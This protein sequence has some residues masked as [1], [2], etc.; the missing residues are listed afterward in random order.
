MH[1]DVIEFAEAILNRLQALEECLLSAIG[2]RTREYVGKELGRVADLLDR[3]AQLVPAARVKAAQL[4]AAL[5][6]LLPA[7]V[8]LGGC[9]AINRCLAL[10]PLQIGRASCRERV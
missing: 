10:D 5:E 3:N 1:R 9:E 4:A 7:P 6:Y 2:F 8:E